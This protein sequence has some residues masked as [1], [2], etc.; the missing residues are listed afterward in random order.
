M[1]VKFEADGMWYEGSF[2]DGYCHGQGI[3]HYQ[4]GAIYY[5]E[6]REGKRHGKGVRF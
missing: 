4:D 2:K 1:G 3:A 5:G 6:F